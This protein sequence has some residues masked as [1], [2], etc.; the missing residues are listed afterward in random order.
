MDSAETTTTRPSLHQLGASLLTSAGNLYADARTSASELYLQGRERLAHITS[1]GQT[2][3]Q[4]G[5]AVITDKLAILKTKDLTTFSPPDE[6]MLERVLL[7][8]TA[9][10]LSFLGI[11]GANIVVK[12]LQSRGF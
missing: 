2:Q 10:R 7:L 6:V 4:A 1:D 9:I 12:L 11:A 3:V 8:D 5:L